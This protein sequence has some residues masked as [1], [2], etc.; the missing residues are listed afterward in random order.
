MAK[1][2]NIE[3]YLSIALFIFLLLILANYLYTVAISRLSEEV[4]EFT[5]ELQREGFVDGRGEIA[6]DDAEEASAWGKYKVLRDDE[7]YDDFYAKV[8]NKI[9]QMDRL[10]TAEAGL[11]YHDWALTMEPNQMKILD[12][13]C[14]T[15]VAA[16]ALKKM[17]V[18]EVT[19]LDLSKAMVAKARKVLE[20]T[21]LTPE[22]KDRVEFIQG[23]A[24]NPSSVDAQGFSHAMVLYFSIYYFKDMDAL[25]RN[26]AHWVRPGGGLAIEVVDKHKFEAIPDS[27][28]PW[29]GI[30]PQRYKKERIT[31]GTVVFDQFEYTSQFDLYDPAAEFTEVFRFKDGTPIRRQKHTLYMYDIKKI[32]GMAE[33]V[34][35]KYEKSMELMP[36]GFPHAWVLFFKRTAS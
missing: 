11:I 6:T 4:S 29:I 13:G 3:Q 27:S 10:T 23:N 12:V 22:E 24:Y 8:Y 7:I 32:V 1:W 33:A 17:G 19:G 28:N 14:G 31:K 25:F 26:L 21:T 16:C 30:N 20:S 35:W 36:V 34:G 9:T 15:G 2:P 18:G 5:P